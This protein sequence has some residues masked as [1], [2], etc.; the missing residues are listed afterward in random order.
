MGTKVSTTG[1]KL[2]K[3]FIKGKNENH[4]WQELQITNTSPLAMFQFQVKY[5]MQNP[6]Q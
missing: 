1:S 2:F 5:R 4:C 6:Y 3:F